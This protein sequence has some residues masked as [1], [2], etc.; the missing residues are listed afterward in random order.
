MSAHLWEPGDNASG[1]RYDARQRLEA[2]RARLEAA[3]A[4]AHVDAISPIDEPNLDYRD[5][6][7]SI[8]AAVAIIRDVFPG[9]RVRCI[10]AGYRAP[11]SPEI[12]D[13][14]GADSYQGGD[15]VLLQGGV[16][17]NFA[18]KLLPHQGLILVPGGADT[19]YRQ[20]TPSEWVSYAQVHLALG[21][22]VEL[23]AFAWRTPADQPV[24]KGIC[25]QPALRAA[26]EA[27]F[28]NLTA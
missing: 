24:L 13:D 22:R 19:R 27:A 26:Y 4:M 23:C 1:L 18:L 25:D 14:I 2:Y 3:G 8:V 15:N 11:C 17:S 9:L 28:R 6:S 21:R 20:P 16:I 12:F 5:K 10:F 7:G